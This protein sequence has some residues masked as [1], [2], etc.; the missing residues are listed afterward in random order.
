MTLAFPWDVSP[1]AARRGSAGPGEARSGKAWL[2]TA[3][4]DDLSTEGVRPF[5]AGFFG[6]QLWHGS[7]RQ[8]WTRQCLVQCGWAR[9]GL[10]RADSSTE[11]LRP[12]PAVLTREQSWHGP[13]GRGRVRQGSA[14]HGS[15]WQGRAWPGKG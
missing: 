13:A 10:A 6:I 7:A 11:G 3:R 1:V 15:T 8:G 5:P 2:G 4:A 12:F 14:R 9:H